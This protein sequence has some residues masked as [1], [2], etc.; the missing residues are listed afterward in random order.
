MMVM[1]LLPVVPM[2][3]G[4]ATAMYVVSVL[5]PRSRPTAATLEKYFSARWRMGQSG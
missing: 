4:S 2:T 1:G 3:I 5:T